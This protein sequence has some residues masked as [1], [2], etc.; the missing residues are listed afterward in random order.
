MSCSTRFEK[1]TSLGM[2]RQA[3]PW[4]LPCCISP[5]IATRASLSTLAN[6]LNYKTRHFET[7]E[8]HWQDYTARLRHRMNDLERDVARLA[9]ELREAQQS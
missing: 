6:T 1:K 4:S 7:V 3:A 8:A 2:P 5:M 9:R